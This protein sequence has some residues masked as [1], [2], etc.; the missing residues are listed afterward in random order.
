MLP[1]IIFLFTV[2]DRNSSSL[3]L[4]STNLPWIR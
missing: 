2:G 1:L 3:G 4:T